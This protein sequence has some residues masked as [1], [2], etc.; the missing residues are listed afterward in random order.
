MNILVTG[1]AGYIGS[2]V[3]V[4]LISA[5]HMPI[6]VDNLSNSRREVITRVEEITDTTIPLH[7]FDL[8][9]KNE[10]EKVFENH[11]I[12][13]VMHF[14]GLK[15]VGESTQQ[16]L[17]YYRTNIDA[18][19]TLLETMEK[20]SVHKL[21]FS[22]SA[23]VYGSAPI[24]YVESYPTGQGITSPYGQAKYVIEQILQDVAKAN[25]QNAFSILRYF[26]PVGAHES[27][28]I[29]EDPHGTPNNLMP[30]V[31]QVATGKREQLLVFGDN[32][33]TTDG[34]GVRDYIHVTDLAKGHL[35]ALEK[36]GSGVSV[37]NLGSGKGMSVFQVVRAFEEASSK[38][39]AYKIVE[40]RPGDLP[41]YYADVSKAE[42]ELNWKTQKTIEDACRDI[43]RWQSHNP[44][45]FTK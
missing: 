32:Y 25:N 2:H 5:G 36:L 45:G 13:A 6:V 10:L 44:D 15:A 12:E 30:I 34:T 26:N 19:L 16:P 24:P 14:A 28:L 17:K 7:V 43:W 11:N 22:S 18:S 8:A 33:D 38:K 39:I 40:R 3:L 41:E 23:T 4:E 37:Y 31:A 1:G 9:N 29:G 20:Y 27:G 35:A 42:R 21:V